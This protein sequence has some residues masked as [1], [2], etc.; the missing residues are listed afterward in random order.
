MVVPAQVS[1]HNPISSFLLLNTNPGATLLIV[2]WQQMTNDKVHSLFSSHHSPSQSWP[3]PQ[4]HNFLP[5]AHPSPKSFPIPKSLPA[6]KVFLMLLLVHLTPMKLPLSDI[7]LPWCTPQPF[8]IP[9]C[10]LF[11]C[12][13]YFLCSVLQ[14]FYYFCRWPNHLFPL[15]KFCSSTLSLTTHIQRCTHTND[16]SNNVATPCHLP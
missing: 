13:L 3:T 11:L 4:Q 7:W 6:L 2:M 15:L 10:E 9:S 5:N 12:M 16:N 14:L 1:Q 8:R